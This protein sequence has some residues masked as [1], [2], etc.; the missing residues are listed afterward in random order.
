MSDDLIITSLNNEARTELLSRTYKVQK[1]L[2]QLNFAHYSI[3]AQYCLGRMLI[4]L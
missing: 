4:L 2:I 3:K 1:S